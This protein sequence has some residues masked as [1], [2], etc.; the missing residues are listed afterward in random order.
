MEKEKNEIEL[1]T[2]CAESGNS[3]QEMYFREPGEDG[4]RQIDLVLVYET[5]TA[6]RMQDMKEDELKKEKI[7]AERRKVFETNLRKAGLEMEY[8]DAVVEKVFIVN[9]I[10]SHKLPNTG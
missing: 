4:K 9:Y 10:V 2:A 7:K 6:K 8:E 5:P 3:G 1:I